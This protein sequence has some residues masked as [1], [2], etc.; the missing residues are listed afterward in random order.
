MSQLQINIG[1]EQLY[2]DITVR[3]MHDVL[4]LYGDDD[5]KKILNKTGSKPKKEWYHA[6]YR[7]LFK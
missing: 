5:I 6:Q 3:R 2:H 4:L 1:K 7:A